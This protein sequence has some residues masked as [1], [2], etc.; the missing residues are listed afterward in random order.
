MAWPDGYGSGKKVHPKDFAQEHG[1]SNFT[2][3]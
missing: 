1:T 2:V 3:S